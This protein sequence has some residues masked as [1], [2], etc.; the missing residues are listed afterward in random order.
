MLGKDSQVNI[1]QK[2][3]MLITFTINT[4]Q[5]IDVV[6]VYSFFSKH[7]FRDKSELF[8]NL[9]YGKSIKYYNALDL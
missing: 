7:Y 5:Y 6:L 8:M 4:V 9:K 1:L 2:V 3:H